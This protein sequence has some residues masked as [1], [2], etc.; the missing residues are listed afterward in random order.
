MKRI[1]IG[2]LLCSLVLL[3]CGGSGRDARNRVTSMMEG[4]QPRGDIEGSVCRWYN[5]ARRLQLD[6]LKA[7]QVG[8]DDW[9]RE[10]SLYREINSWSITSITK[11]AGADPPAMIVSV[12][13]DG[14]GYDMRVADER[15]I[16]W[17]R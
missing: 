6:H 15:P 5:G 11:D 2:V 1:A 17:A 10:K 8:F 7:A 16:E 4:W 9:R 14:Q 13:I 12:D 3:A